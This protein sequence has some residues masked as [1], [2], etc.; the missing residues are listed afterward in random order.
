VLTVLISIG[1]LAVNSYRGQ[2]LSFLWVYRSPNAILVI[3]ITKEEIP[4]L[5]GAGF[6]FRIR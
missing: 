4:K 2:M 1:S 3:L 6:I 5:P